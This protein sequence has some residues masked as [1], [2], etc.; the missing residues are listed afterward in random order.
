MAGLKTGWRVLIAVA[1]LLRGETEP[2]QERHSASTSSGL[3]QTGV[4]D[5]DHGLGGEERQQ[6]AVLVHKR[7][8]A[9][10]G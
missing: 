5:G 7:A 1:T 4:L 8:L 10:L 2:D 3:V 6:R 9:Q